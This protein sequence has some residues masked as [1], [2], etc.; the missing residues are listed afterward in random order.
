MPPL[1]DRS[2]AIAPSDLRADAVTIFPAVPRLAL[3]TAALVLLPAA[4][5][6]SHNGHSLTFVSVAQFEFAPTAVNVTT[7]DTV[8]WDFKGPDTN[9]SVTSDEGQIF[10]FYSDP[11]ASP[12]HPVDDSFAV[13]FPTAGTWTYHC[14]VHPSMIGKVVVTAAGST[15][16]ALSDVR[17]LPEAH[18]LVVRFKLN[19]PASIRATV[20]RLS[21]TTAVGRVLREADFSAPRGPSRRRLKLVG[22]KPGRYQVSLVAIDSSTGAATKAVR[23]GFTLR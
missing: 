7:G 17:L 6:G 14:K 2:G 13:T 12:D 1:S 21:G 11:E 9:H 20:R 4:V 10:T 5:A 3:A 22:I 8:V 19:E 15:R 16:P 18:A 23:R